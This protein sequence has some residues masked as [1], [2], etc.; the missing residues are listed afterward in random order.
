MKGAFFVVQLFF[1]VKKRQ[2]GFSLAIM[3]AHSEKLINYLFPSPLSPAQI[4][5]QS[6]EI[7]DCF[8]CYLAMKAQSLLS[9]LPDSGGGVHAAAIAVAERVNGVCERGVSLRPQA[10]PPPPSLPPPSLSPLPAALRR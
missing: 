5:T 9:P 4:A 8:R 7:L 1:A 3:R 10:S 6:A 2:R